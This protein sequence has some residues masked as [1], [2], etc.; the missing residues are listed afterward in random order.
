MSAGRTYPAQQETAEQQQVLKLDTADTVH[1]HLS[2][3]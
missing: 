3:T 2:G 1:S